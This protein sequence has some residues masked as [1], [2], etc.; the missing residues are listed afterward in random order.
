MRRSALPS[1]RTDGALRRRDMA[2]SKFAA[3]MAN[4]DLLAACV[5]LAALVV[6]TAAGVF[7]RYFAKDPLKWM[8]EA[9]MALIVW[10][11]F[12]SACNV[13]RNSGHIAIDALVNL[14]PRRLRKL[15]EILVHAASTATLAFMCCQSFRFVQQ[16]YA[17]GRLTNLLE[18]PFHVIY[19]V[20]PL[21]FLLVGCHEVMALLRALFR[22]DSGGEVPRPIRS[23]AEGG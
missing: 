8:E 4:L 22:G 5:A 1:R 2:K 9:Q 6:L 19:A 15:M 21:S 16:M 11:V 20:V 23:G 7:M 13:A 10:I 18:I 12:P 3:M 17:R 14:F